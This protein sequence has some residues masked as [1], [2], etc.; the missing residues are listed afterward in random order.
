MQEAFLRAYRRLG[1]YRT[2]DHLAASL[3][4]I[5]ANLGVDHLRR[6]GRW[7]TRDLDA[8]QAAP[9]ADGTAGPGEDLAGREIRERVDEALGTL[10]PRERMA[11]TLRHFEGLRIR[12]IGAAMD[13][14][15][16]AVKNHVFRAVRKMRRALEPL[17]E[18]AR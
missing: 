6:Q 16:N 10:S 5:V 17:K 8:P 11:F 2:P 3:R 4:R 7:R 18:G 1:D 12:E 15:E 13:L 9:L 14:A